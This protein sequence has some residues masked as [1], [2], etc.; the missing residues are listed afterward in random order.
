MDESL[1]TNEC[2]KGSLE[3]LATVSLQFWSLFTCNAE[4]MRETL[5][6]WRCRYI[7]ST[8]YDCCFGV[9]KSREDEYI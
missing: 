2:K 5:D 3:N 1:K 4:Y 9:E 6:V 8:H 7:W